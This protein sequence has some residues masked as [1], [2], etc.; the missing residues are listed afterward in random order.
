LAAKKL[1]WPMCELLLGNAISDTAKRWLK[2][3]SGKGKMKKIRI[4]ENQYERIRNQISEIRAFQIR[5]FNL[6]I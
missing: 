1:A 4:S 5:A 6:A 2:F 3:E